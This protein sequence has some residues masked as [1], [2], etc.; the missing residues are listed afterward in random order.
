M[1]LA[2][3]LVIKDAASRNSSREALSHPQLR[4]P[5]HNPHRLQTHTDLLP[6]Q[7]H[8]I[9]RIIPPVRIVHDPAALIGLDAVLVN[10]PFKRRPVAEAEVEGLG[11]DAVQRQKVIVAIRVLSLDSHTLSTRQSTCTA[12]RN[13]PAAPVKPPAPRSRA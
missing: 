7:P 10:D 8:N 1:I 13:D 11:G 5:L 9:L 3:S 12:A 2:R 4:Q 6:Y